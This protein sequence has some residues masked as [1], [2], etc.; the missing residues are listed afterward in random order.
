M[1]GGSNA[2][3]IGIEEFTNIEPT[4]AG[5]GL[6]A[7]VTLTRYANVWELNG[8]PVADG[9]LGAHEAVT[10][11]VNLMARAQLPERREE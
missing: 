7:T 9:V 11:L 10:G 4:P 8:R 5:A 3:T 2:R 1:K 6:K